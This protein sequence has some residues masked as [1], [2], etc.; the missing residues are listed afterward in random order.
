MQLTG[1]VIAAAVSIPQWRHVTIVLGPL[2]VSLPGLYRDYAETFEK[3]LTVDL[4]YRTPTLLVS[5][6]RAAQA[7][8]RPGKPH[9]RNVVDLGYG[10]TALCTPSRRTFAP[11]TSKHNRPLRVSLALSWS[12]LPHARLGVTRTTAQRRVA[13]ACLKELA[14]PLVR[15]RRCGTGLCAVAL[16][17]SFDFIVGMD[18]SPEMVSKAADKGIYNALD[19]GDIA[20]W[21]TSLVSSAVPCTSDGAP[22][23]LPFHLAVATDVFV[24]IG[25]LAPVLAAVSV[26]LAWDGVFAFS[27]EAAPD[28]ADSD[29]AVA[30]SVG[31]T[32]AIDG[33]TMSPSDSDGTVDSTG[34]VL[35]TSGRFAHSPRY[36]HAVGA[37]C[38]FVVEARQRCEIRQNSGKP[39]M[40]DIY[41]LRKPAPAT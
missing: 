16:Q 29:A 39:V 11:T 5:V 6:L 15:C 25:D 10:A 7:A 30:P 37:A 13:D 41:V 38:G 18:L 31:A 12:P 27:C 40:G 4:H 20:E 2:H 28:D 17:G 19:V 26:A 8:H 34:F 9:W 33:C 24:Y 35:T 22:V 32:A 36:V 1:G 21:L 3:H 14:S 23:R